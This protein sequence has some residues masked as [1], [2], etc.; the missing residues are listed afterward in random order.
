[1]QARQGLPPISKQG[2]DDESASPSSI[3]YRRADVVIGEGG[4]V[5]RTHTIGGPHRAGRNP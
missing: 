2:L 5:V 1:M 4:V 3:H